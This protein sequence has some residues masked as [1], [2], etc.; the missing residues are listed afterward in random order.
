MASLLRSLLRLGAIVS[1]A[2]M[3]F[4]CDGRGDAAVVAD[5][6]VAST[7]TTL[8]TEASSELDRD[9]TSSVEPNVFVDV[10]NQSFDDP[11]VHITLTFN[12][13]AFVDQDF[14]VKG[15]HHVVGFA[16]SLSPGEH[17]LVASSDTG[18]EHVVQVPVPD[19]SPVYVHVGYWASEDQAPEFDS[20]VQDGP[21]V[22]G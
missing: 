4:A 11:D 12:G 1:I 21:F 7:A 6:P 15:Q 17:Q 8:S 2:V 18:A 19:G 9:A 20:L 13:H 3:L 10:T 22:Y 14:P 16:L 5:S